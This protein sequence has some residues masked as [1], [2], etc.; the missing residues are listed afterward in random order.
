MQTKLS[1]IAVF[2]TTISIFGGVLYKWSDIAAFTHKTEFL[3]K[4]VDE[5]EH[6]IED[7]HEVLA[8]REKLHAVELRLL[9]ETKRA[10]SLSFVIRIINTGKYPNDSIYMKSKSGH[11]YTTTIDDY[12]R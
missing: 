7:N 3:Y 11:Y 8:L 2:T 9:G 5:I 12:S 10:D 4:H 6:L 1:L